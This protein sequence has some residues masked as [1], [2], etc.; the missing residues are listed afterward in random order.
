MLLLLAEGIMFLA[1]FAWLMKGRVQF[2]GRV[3]E[4]KNAR[5]VGALLMAPPILFVPLGL[6]VG[7]QYGA[8]GGSLYSDDFL[9]LVMRLSLFELIAVIGVIAVFLVML[10]SAPK[11]TAIAAPKIPENKRIFTVRE[12]AEYL[13]VTESEIIHLIENGTIPAGRFGDGYRIARDI[14]D[15]YLLQ[16]PTDETP[17]AI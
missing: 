12:A 11:V 4:G 8:S 17:A 9:A 6:I 2:L 14:L 13:S 1:G 16:P 15:E 10:F 5:I 3:I 7:L